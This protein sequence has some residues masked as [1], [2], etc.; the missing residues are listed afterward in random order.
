MIHK[1]NPFNKKTIQWNKKK[2]HSKSQAIKPS[3]CSQ[4]KRKE[5]LSNKWTT[6]FILFKLKQLKMETLLIIDVK[7]IKKDIKQLLFYKQMELS[8]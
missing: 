3:N 2:H 4:S 1:A 8:I 6:L 5:P 7:N